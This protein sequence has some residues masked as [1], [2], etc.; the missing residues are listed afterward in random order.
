ME[1]W[2]GNCSMSI[3]TEKDCLVGSYKALGIVKQWVWPVPNIS[4]VHSDQSD[5]SMSDCV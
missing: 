2:K 1:R 5:D 4:T 3:I